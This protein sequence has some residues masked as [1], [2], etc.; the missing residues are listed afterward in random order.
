MPD[1]NA[2]LFSRH[3]ESRRHDTDHILS[4]LGYDAL[5][6]HS[7]R[8]EMR[9]FDD[10]HPPFRANAPFVAWVPQPFAV[11]SLLEIRVG[12]TPRLWF[13]QPDDYWH[14]PPAAPAD[15]WGGEFDLHIVRSAE[16]WHARFSEHRSLAVI[17][18]ER[19]LAA[20]V[21][22]ADLNPPALIQR[23]DEVRTRKTAWEREC[24][25]EA[26]RIAA[27]AHRAAARAF[28]SGASELEIHLA[29]L[30][31][32]GQ[33]QDHM[34][35][36]NIVC[37]NEHAAVLH[38]QHRSPT[39]PEQL[40][41]FLIDAGADCH[42]YAADITRTW[43]APEGSDFD[44]LIEAMDHVQ[45]RLCNRMRAGQSYV[46][47]HREAH[48]GVAGVLEH[49]GLVRMSPDA[50]VETGVSSHFLPHGLG[51]FLGIQVHDVAGKLSPDGTPLP[52]PEA[53]PAL[54]LTRTLEA[55]N[56]VTVEPG[57]YFIPMLLDRLRE[58]AH[59]EHIDW[60]GIDALIPFGGIR[61]EDDVLVTEGDPVNFTRRFLDD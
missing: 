23:L 5:L 36:N 30:A 58:S 55:G 17:G 21:E 45:Q 25:S 29:Y 47:L 38:Y 2:L 43:T 46:D 1:R 12:Q 60:Q 11:D 53:Y 22:N 40:K 15:W 31:A 50:M 32:A 57:L 34:P 4:E 39:R 48:L 8:P 14:V 16:E 28:E 7:G 52:P 26:N 59:A 27:G 44:D 13:C 49:A 9:L 61:I 56:V 24:I 18:H 10:H 37:L 41:S 42:G 54:R 35:Y 19:D 33:D 3:I 51:H 20:L 6:I